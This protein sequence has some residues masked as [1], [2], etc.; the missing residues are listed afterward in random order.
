[1]YFPLNEVV[2]NFLFD[3]SPTHKNC[4][5]CCDL[6]NT[7]TILNQNVFTTALHDGGL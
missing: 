2:F 6:T 3:H 5:K 7:M 1:M 4:L